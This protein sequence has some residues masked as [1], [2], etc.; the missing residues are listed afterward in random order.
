M[1]SGITDL[2]VR[3]IIVPFVILE[4]FFDTRVHLFTWRNYMHS[5]MYQY[6]LVHTI[7]LSKQVPAT[8]EKCL[9]LASPVGMTQAI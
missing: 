6:W 9:L 7:Y 5:E 1:R 2:R 3:G 4:F 8:W